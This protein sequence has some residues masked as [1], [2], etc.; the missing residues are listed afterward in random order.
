MKEEEI[1]KLLDQLK[2][3]QSDNDLS[4]YELA[5]KLGCRSETLSRWFNGKEI[6]SF[7]LRTIIE[8]LK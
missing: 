2:N 5:Q 3:Y 8:F 6:S 4:Q 7:Y 1:K